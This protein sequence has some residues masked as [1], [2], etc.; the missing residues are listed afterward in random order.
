MASPGS[1]AGWVLAMAAAAVAPIASAQTMFRCGS[2]SSKY[3][4]DRPCE[5]APKT[6]LKA[7]G[8]A[9]QQPAYGQNYAP[10]MGTA[11]EILPYLSP[12]CAQLNDAVRTGPARG[13]KGTSMSEL[14]ADY[15]KRCSEDEQLAHKQLQQTKSN[16]R[17]QRHQ[18][19]ASEQA[20]KA[21]AK[22]NIEQCHEML[23]VL[24]GRRQRVASMTA[25]EQRDLDL[26]ETSYRVRCKGA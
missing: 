21:H 11:P 6:T 26:F 16:E 3:L 23:R 18:A 24:A 14:T 19:Q 9:P 22:L 15:R 7:Y 20:E 10:S 25:G 1:M 8:P 17:E 2:G 13:L 12:E 4:S 5:V